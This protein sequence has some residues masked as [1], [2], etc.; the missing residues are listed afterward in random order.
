MEQ[1]GRPSMDPGTA[2]ERAWSVEPTSGE[3]DA[4]DFVRFCYR[5]RHVGW[6]ELYDEMCAVAGR[7]LYHG[8]CADDLSRIGIGFAL[9]EMPALATIV[10][11]VVAED[12]ERRRLSAQTLRVR[13]P[14][15][16]TPVVPA[17]APAAPEGVPAK[18]AAVVVAPVDSP[19]IRPRLVALPAGAI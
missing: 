7:G 13:Y 2:P 10:H 11:R 15:V 16:E 3:P 12:L 9:F 14:A 8:Y 19:E 4:I 1:E 18:T 17:G 5:R 6:P